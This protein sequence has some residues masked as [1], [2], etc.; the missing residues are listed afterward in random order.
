M[1]EDYLMCVYFILSILRQNVVWTKNKQIPISY[2][3][4]IHKAKNLIFAFSLL[5]FVMF[6]VDLFTKYVNF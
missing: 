2:Q 4:Q 5:F 1:Y 6:C 3:H